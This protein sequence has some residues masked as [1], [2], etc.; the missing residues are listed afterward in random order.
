VSGLLVPI[1]VAAIISQVPIS[2]QDT[3][4][5]LA[6]KRMLGRTEYPFIVT[7]GDTVTAAS[8]VDTKREGV[9]TLR[10]IHSDLCLDELLRILEVDKS[11]LDDWEF[12]DAMA[13]ALASYES[14]ARDQ[15][16]DT[17]YR[18][19]EQM[20][21]IPRALGPDLHSRYFEGAFDALEQQV[22]DET[23]DPERRQGLLIQLEQIE[24]ELKSGLGEF[25]EAEPLPE[26][27]EPILNVLLDAFLQ[28]KTLED[29]LE[30]YV[31]AKRIAADP[32]YSDGT[33]G[34]AI[35]LIGK[36]GTRDDFAT[37]LPYLQNESESIKRAT[38]EAIS[39]LHLKITGQPTAGESWEEWCE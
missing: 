6:I 30:I 22:Q 39:D 27:G 15:L 26:S 29:D 17:F 12:Y 38:L 3:L 34:K 1:L 13:G 23:L 16:L 7:I 32:S 2:G 20:K 11:A 10:T 37:L 9:E 19:D 35:L 4:L 25:E 24:I 36:M 8:S 31:L 5:T 33:R 28:M 18:C 21:R 14:E